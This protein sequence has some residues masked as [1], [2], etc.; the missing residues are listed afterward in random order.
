MFYPSSFLLPLVKV[1]KG[2]WEEPT[3]LAQA[4]LVTCPKQYK[5]FQITVYMHSTTC[6]MEMNHQMG[7]I[8]T[9]ITGI[10]LTGRTASLRGFLLEGISHLMTLALA[11]IQN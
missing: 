4:T 3:S 1:L 7:S 11:S 8:S 10:C 2:S 6:G 9:G 5:N